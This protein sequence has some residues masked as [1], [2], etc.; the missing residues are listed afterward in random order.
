MPEQHQGTFSEPFYPG[1]GSPYAPTI[2]QR[3]D[4]QQRDEGPKIWQAPGPQRMLTTRE[5]KD[6]QMS[7]YRSH[8]DRA[9][10]LPPGSARPANVGVI[11]YPSPGPDFMKPS[12]VLPPA[13]PGYGWNLEYSYDRPPPYS[14]PTPA[15][16]NQRSGSMQ[17]SSPSRRSS[18]ASPVG[19]GAPALGP[20]AP[21]FSPP[22]RASS[23]QYSSSHHRHTH[24]QAMS[25]QRPTALPRSVAPVSGYSPHINRSPSERPHPISPVTAGAGIRSPTR[26]SLGYAHPLAQA[27]GW[28]DESRQT[29]SPEP[30]SDHDDDART[31]PPTTPEGSLLFGTLTPSSPGSGETHQEGPKRKKLQKKARTR[32]ML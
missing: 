9:H 21:S 15:T 32:D 10:S 17:F 7:D 31:L 26:S 4:M 16:F 24:T 20:P 12:D 6:L 27:T 3:R 30:Y 23:V 8:R 28:L 22:Q 14:P 19:L 1:N 2:E 18:V 11:A 13:P 29:S 5:L 25:P